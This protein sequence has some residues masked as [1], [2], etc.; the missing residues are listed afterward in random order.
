[1]LITN[2]GNVGIGTTVPGQKLS[3]AGMVESTSGGFKFPD[4]TTQT[5]ASTGG[6][7]S[8]WSTSG[9]DISYDSGNV[10]IGTMTPLQRLTVDGGIQASGLYPVLDF[11]LQG[12]SVA[13][14]IAG[15]DV[16]LKA[17]RIGSIYAIESEGS[18][19]TVTIK[20]ENYSNQNNTNGAGNIIL[21]P[22]VNYNGSSGWIEIDDADGIAR[23]S[24]VGSNVGIGTTSPGGNIDVENGSNTATACINGSCTSKFGPY[25]GL[26]FITATGA[27]TWTVPT[28][29]TKIK[30]TIIG[31]G[32]GG[33]S[34]TASQSGGA[35]GSGA[36]CEAYMNVT[37]GAALTYSVGAG[38]GA[39]AAGGATTFNGSTLS[40][41]GGGGGASG[42]VN[43]AGGTVTACPSG[44][45][46]AGFTGQTPN[47]GS[48]AYAGCF[49][50][51]SYKGYGTGGAFVSSALNGGSCAAGNHAQ[52]YGA[53]GGG[54]A[55]QI[56]GCAATGGSGAAG[57]ILIEY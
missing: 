37:G 38:G 45:G 30:V 46:V 44:M 47:F 53:G 56:S 32:G 17:G 31:G 8:Q 34:T 41:G 25:T 2:A 42:P 39:G 12:G 16:T 1:M 24:V 21:R 54:A 33:A 9:S 49:G 3:V 14:R 26:T 19:A 18:A 10:G 29:V 20:G 4:G 52:G 13:N 15:G 43:G 23:L 51:N 48:L 7:S 6:G 50:G 57:M 35:G 40:V 22:G 55:S 5:T 27:G 36:Y 28:G 11:T